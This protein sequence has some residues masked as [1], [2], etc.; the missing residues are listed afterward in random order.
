M[1]E[2][3]VGV[4]KADV[5]VST[6]VTSWAPVLALVV[7]VGV[8]RSKGPVPVGKIKVATMVECVLGDAFPIPTHML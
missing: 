2:V 3:V 7:G 4:G 5:G 6:L 8:G 1:V